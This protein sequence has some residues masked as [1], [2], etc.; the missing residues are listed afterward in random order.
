MLPGES[1]KPLHLQCPAYVFIFVSIYVVIL[2]TEVGSVYLMITFTMDTGFRL[3]CMGQFDSRKI[4]HQSIKGGALNVVISI[5][6]GTSFKY[7]YRE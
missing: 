2:F 4:H 5:I 3:V 6:H 1:L 7:F